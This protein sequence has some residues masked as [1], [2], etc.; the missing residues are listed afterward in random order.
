MTMKKKKSW[1]DEKS[2]FSIARELG[3]TTA[4]FGWH[5]P[6]N[7][8]FGNHLNYCYDHF[9]MIKD[10]SLLEAL[11]TVPLVS[12]RV[13]NK[14][15]PGFVKEEDY[16]KEKYENFYKEAF[17]VLS[18]DRYDFVYIHWP[19]PHRPEVYNLKFDN[20]IDEKRGYVHN[21]LICDHIINRFLKEIDNENTVLIV[22]SD[23]HLRATTNAAE[24]DNFL[25]DIRDSLEKRTKNLVPFII[26][27]PKEK[28]PL[29]YDKSFNTISLFEIIKSIM[30]KRI[31]NYQDI[32]LYLDNISL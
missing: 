20:H 13:I 16:N 15:F 9:T 23:H 6:Y 5:H 3:Y 31:Q 26:K 1:K 8:I 28:S 19:F 2:I 21:L 18:D 22:T 29:F 11:K 14:V 30:E 4:C 32:A 12:Q 17:K 27:I 7:R 25:R 24:S 10:N